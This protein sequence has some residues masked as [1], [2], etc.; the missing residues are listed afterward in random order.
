MVT[1][2]TAQSEQ[3]T[4]VVEVVQLVMA[5]STKL[6]RVLKCTVVAATFRAGTTSGF[7]V[8]GIL[9]MVQ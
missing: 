4:S 2:V 1:F 9:V 6:Q 7:G 8:I 5:V 3:V